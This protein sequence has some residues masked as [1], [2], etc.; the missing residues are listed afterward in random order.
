MSRN[1]PHQDAI[2]AAG[3]V[4]MFTLHAWPFFWIWAMAY[5][6]ARGWGFSDAATVSADSAQKINDWEDLRRRVAE[7]E[8]NL[9]KSD[10]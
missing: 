10:G 8:I 7:L 6:P 4:S 1:H 5:R 2:Y 3:W 9:Q